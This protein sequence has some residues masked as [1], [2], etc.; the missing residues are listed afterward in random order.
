MVYVSYMWYSC[1]QIFVYLYF[2]SVDNTPLVSVLC[3]LR[4]STHVEYNVDLLIRQHQKEIATISDI[5]LYIPKTVNPKH[6]NSKKKVYTFS[7][8]YC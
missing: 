4:A 3:C 5:V 7:N 1:L 6:S 2:A 8:Y